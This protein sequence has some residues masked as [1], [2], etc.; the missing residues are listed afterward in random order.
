MV[1]YVRIFL[2][3]VLRASDKAWSQLYREMRKARAHDS[4]L[5]ILHSL[6]V[7]TSRYSI[8]PARLV[9]NHAEAALF[10]VPQTFRQ[11]IP[12][13]IHHSVRHDIEAQLTGFAN[14]RV[15]AFE[16][17]LLNLF[18]L[19]SAIHDRTD[20]APPPVTMNPDGYGLALWT[21]IRM[22]DYPRDSHLRTA[23]LTYIRY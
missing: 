10:R 13:E 2:L 20:K 9:R 18:F 7:R 3:L 14:D 12:F 21:L 22:G 15:D 23:K 17:A 6:K 16:V 5:S 4:G 8:H 11:E 1:F 19:R